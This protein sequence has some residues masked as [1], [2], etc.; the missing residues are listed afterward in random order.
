MVSS[1]A[2]YPLDLTYYQTIKAMVTLLDIVED[3]ADVIIASEI[4]E[5]LGS[6]EFR[7]AQQRLVQLGYEEYAVLGPAFTD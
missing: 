1:A 5:G 4:S 3:G 6:E 2:G 7:D